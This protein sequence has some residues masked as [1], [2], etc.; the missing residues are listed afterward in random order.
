MPQFSDSKCC[1]NLWYTEHNVAQS[2]TTHS[3]NTQLCKT[4]FLCAIRHQSNIQAIIFCFY[5]IID[6]GCTVPLRANCPIYSKC[7][8]QLLA[9][10]IKLFGLLLHDLKGNVMSPSC[11]IAIL[12]IA[13]IF[14][15]EQHKLT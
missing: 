3:M 9:E 1:N 12:L 7:T 11:L 14:P 15:K 10:E 4:A 5:Q 8:V 2:F 13:A 6:K